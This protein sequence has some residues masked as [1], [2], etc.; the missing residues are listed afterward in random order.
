MTIT[1]FRND[2]YGKIWMEDNKVY[3][4]FRIDCENYNFSRELKCLQLLS[5]YDVAAGLISY[6]LNEKIIVM[7]YCG[8]PIDTVNHLDIPIEELD[9]Q[10]EDIYQGLIKCMIHHKDL[11]PGHVCYD[12]KKL[13][14][15]DFGWSSIYEDR[16]LYMKKAEPRVRRMV[17][18][19]KT[20]IVDRN[21]YLQDGLFTS[22]V[23]SVIVI[24]IVL[25]LVVI[26]FM[27]FARKINN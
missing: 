21:N 7:K 23:Y 1:K 9:K 27:F 11:I 18:K 19:I 12:G 10:L 13:R 17:N 4:K 2:L 20:Y 22:S 15:I 26:V 24:S 8:Y 25:L 16:E 5:K 14:V 3:K 6:D